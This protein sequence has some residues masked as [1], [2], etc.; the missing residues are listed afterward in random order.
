[1]N[2]NFVL[3]LSIVVVLISTTLGKTYLEGVKGDEDKLLYRRFVKV[4]QWIFTIF[5]WTQT[6]SKQ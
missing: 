3:L 5:F 4:R 2:L 6:E 1:M